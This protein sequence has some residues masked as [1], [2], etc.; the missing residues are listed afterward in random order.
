M[1]HCFMPVCS[2]VGVPTTNVRA[3]SSLELRRH[4]RLQRYSGVD[5]AT[6]VCVIR[7]ISMVQCGPYEL[8]G[9]N[10]SNLDQWVKVI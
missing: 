7:A 8:G 2:L 9:L 10:Y 1:Y 6:P 3:A 4:G 5:I